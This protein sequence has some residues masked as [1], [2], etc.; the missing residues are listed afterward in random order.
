MITLKYSLKLISKDNFKCQN[1]QGRYF[2]S[3]EYKE[4]ED[5]VKLIT[6]AQYKGEVLT[7]EVGMQIIA[8][9]KNKVHPDTSNLSKSI[10]DALQG[11]VYKND[12]QIAEL[13]VRRF[14]GEA[15]EGF[16]V[17]IDTELGVMKSMEKGIEFT[18]W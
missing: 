10:C 14:E 17:E 16:I 5:A 6:K 2:L 3:K 11:I 9:Y 8:L 7:G 4:F 18:K 13:Y 1:R 15:K 12:K